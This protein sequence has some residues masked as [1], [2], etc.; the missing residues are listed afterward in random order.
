MKIAIHNRESSF[1]PHWIEYCKANGIDYKIVNCYSNDI[2]DQLKD[3]C[4][5]MWHHYHASAK[6]I[7][8][9]KQLLY[10]LQMSGKIV[11]PDFNTDWHFND[12]L[13]QKYLLEAIEA[14]L[15]PS[16]A[17]YEKKEALQWVKQTTFP[18]VFKLRGGSGSNNVRLVTQKNAVRF[19]HKAFKKGFKQYHPIANLKERIR[20]YRKG[21]TSFDDV[22]K[23]LVRI[24]L[25]T[26][27]AHIQGNDRGYIYFQDFIPDNT[28][29]IRVT[30]V[31]NKCF[32]LRRRVRKGDFRASGSGMIEYDMSKIP[33]QALRI[34]FEVAKRL[35][36]QTA[37]FDFVMY[38]GS[39]LIVELSYGFGY[40]VDQFN[41]GYWDDQL[42]YHPGSFNPYAWMVE[43]IIEKA[44]MNMGDVVNTN[45]NHL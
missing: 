10:S 2:V 27:Y 11:F 5:I 24:V 35:K 28:H 17:F 43:G 18:K 37:A 14:P 22:L 44:R 7:Q 32:A 39:P 26:E 30:Y 9:A 34:A 21:K 3:C 8:F 20:K 13:G 4:A 12:K 15:V 45:L 38:K 6:D 36:L 23:G 42:K 16:Y 25:P 41:H 19:I 31:F 1:S 29:D 40:D 33:E